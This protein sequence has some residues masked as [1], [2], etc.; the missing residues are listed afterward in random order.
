MANAQKKF[1]I[2]IH[3]MTTKHIASFEGDSLQEALGLAK[4]SLGNALGLA[5]DGSLDYADGVAVAWMWGQS[6]SDTMVAR[7]WKALGKA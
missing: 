2:D 3:D 4:A 5:K 6:V 7:A 1:S